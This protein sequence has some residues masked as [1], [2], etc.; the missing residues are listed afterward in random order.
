M[1]VR[2]SGARRQRALPV[3][4]SWYCHI[5]TRACIAAL[6]AQALSCGRGPTECQWHWQAPSECQCQCKQPPNSSLDL[7]HHAEFQGHWEWPACQSLQQVLLELS[8]DSEA[9]GQPMDSDSE[10]LAASPSSIALRLRVDSE[11]PVQVDSLSVRLL[12]GMWEPEQCTPSA[13]GLVQVAATGKIPH[14]SAHHNRHW[15]GCKGQA[16]LL[17]TTAM[18][19]AAT[20]GAACALDSYSYTGSGTIGVGVVGLPYVNNMDIGILL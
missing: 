6:Y 17:C 3:L 15:H 13:R 1:A 2:T 5:V 7:E 4:L 8:A 19:L 20:L 14:P 16:A 10:S 12:L 18:I 9:E 11:C